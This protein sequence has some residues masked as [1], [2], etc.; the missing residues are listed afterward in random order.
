[1]DVTDVGCYKNN[2]HILITE[3]NLNDLHCGE[4]SVS[5][6]TTKYETAIGGIIE[7]LL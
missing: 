6:N 4:I 3:L 2:K 5:A 1:M 7:F